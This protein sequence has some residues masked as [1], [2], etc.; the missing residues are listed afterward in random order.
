[1]SAVQDIDAK[2]MGRRDWMDVMKEIVDD[3]VV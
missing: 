1:M 2:E 3:Y